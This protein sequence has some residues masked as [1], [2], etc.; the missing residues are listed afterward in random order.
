MGVVQRA[1]G[2]NVPACDSSDETPPSYA[3]QSE[4]GSGKLPHPVL[5]QSL[6]T[7]L[8]CPPQFALRPGWENK[9][10]LGI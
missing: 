10:T 7:P 2:A 9:E 5:C 6:A 4:L 1:H 8:E 3:N